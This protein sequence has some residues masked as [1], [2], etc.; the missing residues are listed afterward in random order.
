[1]FSVALPLSP[2]LLLAPALGKLGREWAFKETTLFLVELP[3]LSRRI[4]L[5]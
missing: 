3:L 1:M 2:P 5:D 4:E